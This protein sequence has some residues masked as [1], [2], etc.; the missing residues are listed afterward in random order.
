MQPP[1]KKS[2]INSS[3]F[4]RFAATM[5]PLRLAVMLLLCAAAAS[6]TETL[7]VRTRPGRCLLL[8]LEPASVAMLDAIQPASAR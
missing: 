5:S 4:Y 6:A 2:L 1:H 7:S 8:K 3:A